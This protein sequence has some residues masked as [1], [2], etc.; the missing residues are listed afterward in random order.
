MAHIMAVAAACAL[1]LPFFWMVSTSLKPQAEVLAYPPR[2]L[3]G[4]VVWAN[5]VQAWQAAPFG[6]FYLNSTVTGTSAALLQVLIAVLMAYAFAVIRFPGKRVLLLLV[7]AAMMVPEEVKLVPNYLLMRRFG[8]VNS[9]WAL[10][11]P[12]AA[13]AF[14][15]FVLYQQFRSL[16][17]D[18]LQSARVDG[19]NHLRILLHVVGPMSR[20]ALAAVGLVAFLGRWNDYLWPLIATN[21]LAMRTLPIGLAYL[22]DTEDSGSPWNILMAGTILVI[23]PILLLYAVA[24]RQFVEG[25]TQGALK[26]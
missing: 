11:V 25:I 8:W 9:Y 7:I 14:P 10:I 4:S 15:V 18:V 1:A 13:H 17:R 6:R 3:P 19:A 24:Q 21:T 23:M 2:W 22:K 5:Y 26:G 12:P 20:P 16:P